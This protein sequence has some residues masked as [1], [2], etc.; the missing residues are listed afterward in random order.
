[1]ITNWNCVNELDTPKAIQCYGG[2]S[3]HLSKAE[4]IRKDS[5]SKGKVFLHLNAG[6]MLGGFIWYSILGTDPAVESIKALNYNAV[7]TVYFSYLS[8][9]L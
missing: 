7:V 3:R 1:M 8:S 2:V 6:G 4:E 9:R 5:E